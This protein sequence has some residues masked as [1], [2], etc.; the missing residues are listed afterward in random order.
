M[1][2]LGAPAP[3]DTP[4]ISGE[5]GAVTAGLL[6]LLAGK[7][8][9]RA[10]RSQ[11]GLDENAVVLLF[12]TEGDTDPVHYDQVVHEGKVPLPAWQTRGSA[13]F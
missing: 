1:R 7:A 9:C 5:S 2:V 10:L 6:A 12:S 8:E 4:V 3:G 13:P 11:T